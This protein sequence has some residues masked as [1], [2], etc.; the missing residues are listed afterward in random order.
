MALK[1]GLSVPSLVSVVPVRM[2]FAARAGS[3]PERVAVAVECEPFAL[4]A[5]GHERVR[6]WVAGDTSV[7]VEKGCLWHD[8]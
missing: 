4:P 7:Y 5:S 3:V 6:A 8:G 1:K 2:V